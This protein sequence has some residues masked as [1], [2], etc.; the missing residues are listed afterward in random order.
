MLEEPSAVKP[1]DVK[2][3]EHLKE[4]VDPIIACV[5]TGKVN[6]SDKLIPHTHNV[7][8]YGKPEKFEEDGFGDDGKESYVISSVDDFNKYST[9]FYDCTGLIVAGTERKTGKN[10]SFMSHQNPDYFLRKDNQKLEKSI[11]KQI[12]ALKSQCE[13]GTIDAVIVGGRYAE[14]RGIPK[15]DPT[16]KK[17]IEEY[18]R[19]VKFLS[20]TVTK[21]LGFEP[22]VLTGPKTIPAG[23]AI[24]YENDHRKLFLVRGA[25][26][27]NAI[28]NFTPSE[29]EEK[30]KNWKPGEWSVPI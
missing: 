26:D 19:S 22:L 10:I 24:F 7:D 12:Q 27:F 23:D 25:D 4:G 8:F 13:S 11:I 20:E 21:E 30:R 16:S 2:R 29:L 15:N 17:Y 9:E 5:G 18:L 3:G 28:E 14:V 1:I 6:D